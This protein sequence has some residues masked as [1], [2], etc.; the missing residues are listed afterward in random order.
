MA[1]PIV[2]HFAFC[3]LDFSL[4][5]YGLAAA[6]IDSR[7]CGH[8]R[9]G[10]GPGCTGAVRQHSPAVGDGSHEDGPAP[11]AGV[12]QQKPAVAGDEE[13]RGDEEVEGDILCECVD[14]DEDEVEGGIFDYQSDSDRSSEDAV[15]E[16][17][18]PPSTD[19]ASTQAAACL[20]DAVTQNELM[21]QTKLG[22]E[23]IRTPCIPMTWVCLPTTAV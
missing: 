4:N 16:T 17:Q 19:D 1:L 22:G 8:G 10:R 13:D 14:G 6:L 11:A 23:L 9:P 7:I 18:A 3:C 20:Q 12:L 15:I 5:N 2:N 21:S